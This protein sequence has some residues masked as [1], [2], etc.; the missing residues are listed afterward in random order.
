MGE[1]YIYEYK[2]FEFK[3][4][5]RGS[6]FYTPDFYLPVANR[7]VEVKGR[8]TESDKTKLKRFKK[9]YLEEFE[10]LSFI[11]PDIY[12][13]SKANGKMIKFLCDG[14]GIDFE[15]IISYK[16]IEEYGGLI[17]GWE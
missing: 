10:R 9:Y 3:G 5:K 2:E 12:S 1:S 8:F 15:E 17:P 4:I 16:E 6:R 14:L 7:W 11:I 13:R